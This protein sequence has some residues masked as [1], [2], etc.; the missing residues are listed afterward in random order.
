MDNFVCVYA[1]GLKTDA[2]IKVITNGATR[3]KYSNE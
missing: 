1:N 2:F 3:N